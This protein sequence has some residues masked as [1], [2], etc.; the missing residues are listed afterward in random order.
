M[1]ALRPFVEEYG[2]LSLLGSQLS[3]F[4]L[5]DVALMDLSLHWLATHAPRDSADVMPSAL[6]GHLVAT[7]TAVAR[8][9]LATLRE[10]APG[11]A[12]RLAWRRAHEEHVRANFS[13]A[14]VSHPGSTSRRAGAS[15]ELLRLLSKTLDEPAPYQIHDFGVAKTGGAHFLPYTAR[16][17]QVQPIELLVP[18]VRTAMKP[19]PKLRGRSINPPIAL[20]WDTLQRIAREVDEREAEPK[21]PGWLKPLKLADRLKK[22]EIEAVDGGFFRA[23]RLTLEGVQ[24]VVG[25]LS[26]G[27]STLLHALVFALVSPG[28]DK[29]VGMIVADTASGAATVARLKAHGINATLISSFPRRNVHLSALHWS[30]SRMDAERKLEATAQLTEMLGVACPLHGFNQA[31]SDPRLA[32]AMLDF[33]QRPC[34]RL[35]Q[36][37][38]KKSLTCPLITQCPS[39]AGQQNLADSQ[40]VVMTAQAMLWMTPDKTVLSEQMSFPELFQFMLDVLLV[41]EADSVQTVFDQE[42]TQDQVLLSPTESAFTASSIR[43][44]TEAVNHR[45]GGQYVSPIHVQWHRT[46]N[47]L[48]DSIS[49]IY[50]LL[51]CH[52]DSL[53]WLTY[54]KPF[55]AASVL[56]D[57]Y[58]YAGDHGQS[59]QQDRQVVLERIAILASSLYR[60]SSALP[61]D[62]PAIEPSDPGELEGAVKC[63]AE[64]RLKVL[65]TSL[66]DDDHPA[67]LRIQDELESGA[68]SWILVGG[69]P[70]LQRRRASVRGNSGFARPQSPSSLAGVA[71]CILLA[72]LAN[73]CLASYAYLVRHHGAVEQEFELAGDSAFRQAKRIMDL[74]GHL[75]PRP[76]VGTVYGLLFEEAT[77]GSQGGVLRLV[78]HLGVGRY[79]LTHFNRLQAASIQSGP[80]TLLVSGT[81]WA[82][83][84]GATASPTYDLQVPVAGILTQP[85]KERKAIEQSQYQL[86]SI[87]GEP[88]RVSGRDPRERKLTLQRMA[89]GLVKAGA[90]AQSILS[91]RWSELADKPQYEMGRRRRALLVTNNYDDARLVANALAGEAKARHL[92]YCL[93]PDSLARSRE[94]H[95]HAVAADTSYS[96]TVVWLPRSQIEEFGASPAES[97]LVAPLGP[98]SRGH[99]IVTADDVPVAAISSIYFLH[100]PFPRPDSLDRFTGLINRV[101]HDI[102]TGALAPNEQVASMRAHSDWASRTLRST[103]DRGFALRTSYQAMSNDAREQYAWDLLTSVW[104]TIGRGIRGGVPV[105]VAFCDE[106]FS[107]GLFA[108]KL[109]TAHS[110]CLVQI[111]ETLTKAVSQGDDRKTAQSLYGP[112]NDALTSMLSE[113]EAQVDAAFAE[114]EDADV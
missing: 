40:V 83:G 34:H 7:L 10:Y 113:L 44:V 59:E 52:A 33:S 54:R 91:R 26:S 74:Y 11:L 85:A 110:S 92:V 41:D 15:M 2:R 37:T 47:R 55:T 58:L 76:L 86:L 1:F 102:T 21:F 3:Y 107:P 48:Q 84:R 4:A 31:A 104:Q 99:N 12:S 78:N 105:Y 38:T 61:D 43:S 20:E 89:V 29:R 49:A 63:L 28:Y 108:G 73:E 42:C 88:T 90:S 112:F 45:A 114:S 22:V 111:K 6:Q 25:M 65:D 67:L 103:V 13:T 50:H 87:L 16:A 68:L 94:T 95:K 80:H 70:S 17:N 27:K 51:I 35:D 53:A 71:R 77:E 97:I 46:L 8:K 62:D 69:S 79:L 36:G 82:G 96:H 32:E 18:S 19:Q 14:Y 109:D 93:V 60:I 24:H 64:L 23:G 39:H 81:S 101:A 98:A 75:L 56:A 57:I 5:R 9:S 30:T 66:Y 100:R 106:R 72:V